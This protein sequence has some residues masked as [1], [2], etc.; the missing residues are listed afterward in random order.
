MEDP[1]PEAE[2]DFA[3]L[4]ID[5]PH[6]A[7]I[8]PY[9]PPDAAAGKVLADKTSITMP[10]GRDIRRTSP[11]GLFQAIKQQDLEGVLSDT[12]IWNLV[13]YA[14]MRSAGVESLAAGRA[15]YNQNCLACHGQ[16]GK[17]DGPGSRY[18][19]HELPD[20]TRASSA[21]GATSEMY[22]AKIRRGGMGTG[23]PY[24]GT[25]FTTEE[26]WNL[27]DYLWS[28]FFTYPEPD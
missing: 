17:G 15:L 18:L 24:W 14:W 3:Q 6:P 4:D 8:Y 22:F 25:I 21:A 12:E 7:A 11:A 13:A 20:F 2:V 9:E 1:A 28:F 5:S 19:E 23:M 27:V 10:A 16:S 26:T